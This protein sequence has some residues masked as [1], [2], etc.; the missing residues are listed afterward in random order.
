MKGIVFETATG[1]ILY[2]FDT[3]TP[4]QLNAGEDIKQR[5]DIND[6]K[7]G[8]IYTPATDIYVNPA[9]MPIPDYKAQFAAAATAEDRISVL[10]KYLGLI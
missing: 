9:V 7:A 4:P 10:A 2:K 5:N 6:I 1:K 3:S 8:A